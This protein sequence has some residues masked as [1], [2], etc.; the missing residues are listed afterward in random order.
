MKVGLKA[1]II[2]LFLS[3]LWFSGLDLVAA[4]DGVSQD[5]SSGL[6]AQAA[7]ADIPAQDQAVKTIPGDALEK[8][9]AM[10]IQEKPQGLS[11]KAQKASKRKAW[12]AQNKAE[13]ERLRVEDPEKYAQA[14]VKRKQGKKGKQGDLGDLKTNSKFFE[15]EC[16]ERLKA[17]DSAIRELRVQQNNLKEMLKILGDQGKA[18]PLSPSSE[19][20]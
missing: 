7:S 3:V 11:E 1:S 13:L 8:S 18:G 20:K 10:D 14:M 2:F 19:M 15:E 9:G 4:E 12:L 17:I 16:L 6:P 5:P